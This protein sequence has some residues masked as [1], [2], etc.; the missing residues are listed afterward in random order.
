[1]KR[2]GNLLI[3]M[4]FAGACLMSTGCFSYTKETTPV[5]PVAVE[6]SVTVPTQSSTTT[7]TTDPYGNVQKNTTTTYTP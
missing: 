6:P 5:A 4:S 3:V 7:T 1:M 2:I